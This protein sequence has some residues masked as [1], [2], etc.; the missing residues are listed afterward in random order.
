MPGPLMLNPRQVRNSIMAA[1][2]FAGT[3]SPA[4]TPLDGISDGTLSLETMVSELAVGAANGSSARD[5]KVPGTR[6]CSA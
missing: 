2:L 5:A 3:N 6:G 4:L 1:V